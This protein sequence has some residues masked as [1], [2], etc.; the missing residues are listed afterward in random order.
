MF[1]HSTTGV[2]TSSLFESIIFKN[3][4]YTSGCIIDENKTNRLSEYQAANDILKW[5]LYDTKPSAFL[6]FSKRKLM[7]LAFVI[8]FP[9]HSESYLIWSLLLPFSVQYDIGR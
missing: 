9:D 3:E 2:R 6:N 8:A 4:L 5:T 1:L 7:S